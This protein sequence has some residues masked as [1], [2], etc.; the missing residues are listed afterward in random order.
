ML[1]KIVLVAMT[2]AVTISGAARAAERGVDLE[3][4]SLTVRVFTTG[5]FHQ[6]V[7]S[8]GGMIKVKDELT[9]AFTIAT[10]T[11]TSR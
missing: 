7:T 6:P 8:F 5:V 2:I 4:S 10:V 9:V 11:T 1:T 3:R